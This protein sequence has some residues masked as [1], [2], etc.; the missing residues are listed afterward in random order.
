MSSIKIRTK[1]IDGKIQIRTLISHPMEHGRNRNKE[2]NALIPAHF[3]KLLTVTH[4]DQVIVTADLS[5]SIS[6][7]PYFAFMLKSGHAG[8]KITISWIDDLG[9]RDSETH[10]VK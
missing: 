3:I 5:T 9:N 8:D 10:V 6:K 4:N 1:R 7:D 2:T